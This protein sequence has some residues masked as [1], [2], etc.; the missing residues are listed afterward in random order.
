MNNKT[1]LNEISFIG[2]DLKRPECVLCTKSGTLYASDW[3]GGVSQIDAQGH[4][5]AFLSSSHDFEVKPNGI[6]L[7]PDGSFLL[8]HLGSEEGGVYRLTRNGELNPF[9]FELESKILPPTNF[10]HIDHE[11]RIWITISTRIKPRHLAYRPETSDGFIICVDEDEARI[12]ADDLGYTNECLVHPSGRW[13]YVNE[14][15][16]RRLSRFEITDHG[17]LVN[18]TTVTEFGE[19]VFPDGLTFD[20]EGGIWV[21]SI[22]SNQVIRVD[23]NGKQTIMLEDNDPD[24]VAWVEQAFQSGEMGRPHLDGIK[25]QCLKNI[26][27]LAFGGK[28]LKTIYLGCLLGDQIACWHSPIVGL[29][30]VHWEFE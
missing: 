16:A 13:L 7:M 18:K 27:S 19:G 23:S 5:T 17:Y 8:A 22:V 21:T 24:H 25:S 28:D 26:S 3:R 11:G 15:F 20:A 4:Q 2:S 30:P 10:V 14:T 9:L 29:P 6:A 1:L 12:V